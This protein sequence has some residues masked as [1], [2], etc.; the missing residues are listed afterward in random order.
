MD[1]E[2]GFKMPK[3]MHPEFGGIIQDVTEREG[4]ELQPQEIFDTFEK[5]YLNAHRTI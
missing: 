1:K 5:D 4:R 3:A 2:F